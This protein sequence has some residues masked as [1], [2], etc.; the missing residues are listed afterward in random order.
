MPHPARAP[1]IVQPR[2]GIQQRRCMHRRLLPLEKKPPCGLPL[3]HTPDD[4]SWETTLQF[5]WFNSPNNEGRIMNICIIFGGASQGSELATWEEINCR[6]PAVDDRMATESSIPRWQIRGWRRGE[7]G[8]EPSSRF[9]DVPQCRAAWIRMH[10]FSLIRV[11]SGAGVR[12]SRS[13]GT[14]DAVAWEFARRFTPAPAGRKMLR[15]S[16]V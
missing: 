15:Q 2:K 16:K 6:P 4:R 9:K 13:P 12:Q 3:R 14:D 8:G 1:R 7:V 5:S 11:H 10:E